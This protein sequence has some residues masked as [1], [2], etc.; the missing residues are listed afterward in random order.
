M[1][2]ALFLGCT[3]P[4][5][6]RNYEISTRKVAQK[7]GIELIDLPEF[8]CCGFPVKSI[9]HDTSLL[10]AARNLSIAGDAGL[11][12]CTVCSACTGVLTEASKKL[13]EDEELREEVN[14][15]LKQIGR[16]YKGGVKVRHFARILYE[17]VG[18]DKIEEMVGRKLSQFKIAPHYGCHYLKPSELFDGFDEPEYPQTLDKLIE[19]TGAVSVDYMEKRLCCG[20]GILAIDEGV[21]LGMVKRKLD[22]VREAGA[23]GMTLICPFCSVMYDDNQRKVEASFDEEYKIPVLY[24][25]QLL[26]LALGYDSKELGLQMN[27]VKT[28]ELLSRLEV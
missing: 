16:S 6:A 22:M 13:E 1:R 10:M 4:A 26:G 8:A 27:R 21:S 18:V 20:G 14:R 2:Y 15:Q 9:K 7:M 17:E 25:P 23:D 11:D 28:K 5:R 24:Y 12:I 19:A 3:V